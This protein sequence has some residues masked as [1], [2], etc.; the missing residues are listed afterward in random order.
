MV[1][2]NILWVINL[3]ILLYIWFD[4]DAFVEWAGFF[5][6]KCL[7]YK[8][9]AENKK[10]PLPF[11]AAQSYADFL[12]YR[13]GPSSFFIRGIT[14]PICLAVWVNVVLLCV[15]Y[16]KVKFSMLGTNILLSWLLYHLLK[17]ILHKL[18]DA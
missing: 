5:R 17:K 9:Y 14:C 8:E 2:F 3:V 13:Y 18:N 11:M 6:L 7:K 1:C 12:A 16:G 10:S 4:T 15:C